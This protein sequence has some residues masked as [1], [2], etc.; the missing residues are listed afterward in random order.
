[1]FLTLAGSPAGYGYFEKVSVA[2]EDI[3]P[4]LVKHLKD[5]DKNNVGAPISIATMSVQVDADARVSVNGKAPI[6][7]QPTIGLS[8]DAVGVCSL[9]FIT[10]GIKYNICVSY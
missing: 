6:L 8:F 10:A 7:I 1:M 5:Y 2:N 9:K 4:E 3:M